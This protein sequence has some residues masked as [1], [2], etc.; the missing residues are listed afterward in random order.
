[1]NNPLDSVDLTLWEW[2]VL[3]SLNRLRGGRAAVQ[4]LNPARGNVGTTFTI[5]RSRF[6]CGTLETLCTLISR[7]GLPAKPKPQ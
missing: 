2:E 7:H 1:M 6:G 5:L 3:E 4:E